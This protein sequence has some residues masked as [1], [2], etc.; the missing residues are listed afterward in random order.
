MSRITAM[1]IFA[2]PKEVTIPVN[3]KERKKGLMLI[4]KLLKELE[5]SL[6]RK[7]IHKKTPKAESKYEENVAVPEEKDAALST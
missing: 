1:S 3:I 5:S 7:G 2:L 4:F 6:P